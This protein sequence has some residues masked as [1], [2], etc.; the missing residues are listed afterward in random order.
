MSP[1]AALHLVLHA[2]IPALLAWLLF[3][4]RFV[5]AAC[6]LLAGWAIDID[7]LLATP[8]YSAGRCSLGFHPLHTIPAIVLYA[9]LM[10]AKPLRLLG[11]GLLIH[12]ALDG[13]DCLRM[14]CKVQSLTMS[15]HQEHHFQG[16]SVMGPCRP[17]LLTSNR[18]ERRHDARMQA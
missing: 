6:W 12:I 5:W 15:I 13:I 1:G 7:H 8:I 17:I 9:T 14:A 10:V 16:N 4:E 18:S 11:L 2:L 3:R